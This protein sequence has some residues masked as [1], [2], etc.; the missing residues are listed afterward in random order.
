MLYIFVINQLTKFLLRNL[1]AVIALRDS[2]FSGLESS[3]AHLNLTIGSM[4]SN[5]SPSASVTPDTSATSVTDL[6]S[7]LFPYSFLHIAWGSKTF[8]LEQLLGAPLYL[9][10]GFCANSIT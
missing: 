8:V 6:C 4:K 10:H 2:T 5:A 1:K 9:V 7:T 3:C